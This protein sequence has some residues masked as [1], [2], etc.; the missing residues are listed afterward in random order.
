MLFSVELV[1]FC[2]CLKDLQVRISQDTSSYNFNVALMSDH[3]SVCKGEFE[4]DQVQL[5]E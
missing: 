2:V 3:C 1:H 5:G 4:D